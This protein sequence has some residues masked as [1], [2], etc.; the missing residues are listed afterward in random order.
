MSTVFIARVRGFAPGALREAA[1]AAVQ[2]TLGTASLR[3]AA[4]LLKPNLCNYL[5]H[6]MGGT[7]QIETMEA[8]VKLL[9]DL[10]ASKVAVG[11]GCAEREMSTLELFNK[12]GYGQIRGVEFIDFNDTALPRLTLANPNPD[13]K[14]KTFSLPQ[15]LD[16]FDVVLNVAKMKTHVQSV[17]TL[18]LKN[19]K[20][21]LLPA[22]KK[23]SHFFGVSQTVAELNEVVLQYLYDRGKR[24][25][26]MIDGLV[27]MEGFGPTAGKDKPAG[28][29]LASTAPLSLDVAATRIMG[30]DP[31]LVPML[32]AAKDKGL[33]EAEAERIQIV[34]ATLSEV[35]QN[36]VSPL[37]ALEGVKVSNLE[38]I[39]GEKVCSGCL[40]VISHLLAADD[41]LSHKFAA[42]AGQSRVRVKL[43]LGNIDPNSIPPGSQVISV[44]N[45]T[46]S[47]SGYTGPHLHVKGCPPRRSYIMS[48]IMGEES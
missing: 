3:G 43:A 6:S 10:G 42:F 46:E 11:E 29:I 17:V 4:V 39:I 47:L 32:Q 33:G 18:S 8:L 35:A 24:Y 48:V 37:T 12:S 28:L 40:A 45:C 44:G 22:D 26:A 27:G 2:H 36:F 21:L 41:A 31:S 1:E 15:A 30:I 13:S 9:F 38:L 5:P 34:G 20:G 7:V 19:M 25:L 16:R 14:F 23:M